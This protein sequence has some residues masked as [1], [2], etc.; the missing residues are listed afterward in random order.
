MNK[1]R[2]AALAAVLCLTLSGCSALSLNGPDLLTPPNAQGNQAQIQKLIQKNA[3]SK[4]EMVYPKG[5]EYQSS[6]IFHDLDGDGY[7]EAVAM[8]TTDRETMRILIADNIGSSYKQLAECPISAVRPDTVEFADFDGDGKDEILVCYPG[9][10]AALKSLTVITA[11]SEVDQ[12]DM[13]NACS[14]H[15]I[16][17]YNGDGIKDLL[18]LAVADGTTLPTARLMIDSGE[19]LKEQSVCEVASD[20]TQYASLSFGKINDEITGAVVDGINPNGEYSTQLICYDYNVRGII[21]PLYLNNNYINTRR[22][23]AITSADINR[24][25]IIEIPLCSAMEYAQNEDSA[26]VCD[27]ID[28]SNYDYQQ[29]ELVTKQ[30]AVLCD[31]L[32]FLL[33][34]D[35][36]RAEIVTARYTGENSMAL[37]LWEYKHSTPTRTIKLL[38]IKRYEKSDYDKDSVLE[39]VAGENSDY[40]YTYVIESEEGYYA[41]TDQAVTD[42]FV[43]IDTQPEG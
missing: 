27:R 6:V 21:N 22:A 30:S 11:G 25:G 38:S 2:F 43:L 10:A 17:D 39:A 32:G 13:L 34:L 4:Y 31:R 35:A 41:Y 16:G 7:E 8:Y 33:N 20:V 5:G 1:L 19:G 28:W 37:Y 26:S 29:I 3:G 14:A 23:A 24:D 40:V 9:S 18:T 42:N 15:L 36:E 12:K